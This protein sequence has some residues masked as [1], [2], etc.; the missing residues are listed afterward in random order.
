M[1]IC[2]KVCFLPAKCNFNLLYASSTTIFV[3]DVLDNTH[4]RRTSDIGGPLLA[5]MV[6]FKDGLVLTDI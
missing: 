4:F 5:E 6:W 2:Y 3:E 1:E